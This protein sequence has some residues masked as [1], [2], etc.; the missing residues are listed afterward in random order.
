MPDSL[1]SNDP[2]YSV[3]AV[4]KIAKKLIEN[5]SENSFDE[6]SFFSRFLNCE[7]V[8]LNLNFDAGST[9]L[10]FIERQLNVSY[11]YDKRFKGN[12]ILND[13]SKIINNTIYVRDLNDSQAEP[14]FEAF[15]SLTREKKLFRTKLLGRGE[16]G[17]IKAIDC[18]DMLEKT[19]PEQPWLLTKAGVSNNISSI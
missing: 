4:G 10:H 17:C 12:I 11:R 19:L 14:S 6:N 2:S 9:F 5:P 16:L 1:R 18:K 3:V 7:G 15:T 13:K 8:I